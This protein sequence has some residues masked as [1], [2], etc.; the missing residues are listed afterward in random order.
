[1]LPTRRSIK[2]L[3]AALPVAVACLL[4]VP[5][6]AL[7]GVVSLEG[8]QLVYRATAGEASYISLT[9]G[10]DGSLMLA[11]NERPEIA[12]GTPCAVKGSTPSHMVDCEAQAPGVTIHAGDGNDDV[13]VSN[14]LGV[15]SQVTV[16]GGPGNDKLVGPIAPQQV[17]VTLRGGDGDDAVEG[18]HGNDTLDGG[19]GADKIAGDEGDDQLLGGDGDDEL[20]GDEGADAVD[21][22]AGFDKSNNDWTGADRIAVSL[23]GVADDGRSGERDNFVSVE[24]I[25]TFV[26]ATLIAGND[27]VRFEVIQ[28]DG[29]P[30][31]LVGSPGDDRLRSYDLGDTIEGGAGKD[32]IEA[33]NGDDT[34]N[35][36]PGEDTVN[37]EAG[38]GSCNFLVCRG[39]FGND[40]I[41]ARDGERD[42]IDCG[43]GEDRVKAD[44][45]DVV[46]ANCETVERPAAGGDKQGGDGDKGGQPQTGCTVPA[47]KRAAP[48]SGARA[49]LKR[50][51]CGVKVVRVRSRGV[52][53]GRVV[54]LAIRTGGKLKALKTGQSLKAGTTVVVKVSTGS[55]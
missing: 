22:G 44:A 49:K 51:G 43:I 45:Q 33:G 36:G 55:K 39:A 5:P 1:M 15:T 25:Y 8:G 3:A 6:G 26:A 14:R 10:W 46:A 29:A 50:A 2:W 18:G 16:E 38:P 35:P 21:G 11:D 7:A 12:P 27:P 20:R 31:R 17:P 30:T 28:G 24:H 41:D 9:E 52:R 40:T 37:A 42:S 23:D 13:R 54:G 48:L 19:P 34:I 47:V 53:K 4:T 32:T